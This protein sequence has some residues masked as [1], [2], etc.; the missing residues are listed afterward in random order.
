MPQ[1]TTIHRDGVARCTRY[2]FGPNKLHLCGPDA[3]AEVFAYMKEGIVDPGLEKLLSRFSTLYPYLEHIARAN[4]IRDPFDDRVVHAYWIGNELLETITPQSFYTHLADTLD[5][6]H[7]YTPKEF[8]QLARKLPQGARMHHSFHVFNAYKRTGHD[9]RFHNLESMDSCRI[10]WG[11]VATVDGPTIT[12]KRKP[13]I[14]NGHH[15]GLGEEENFVVTRQLQDDVEFDE[16]KPGDVLSLHWGRLCEV[17]SKQDARL[18]EHYTNK[19][20]ALTN[21]TL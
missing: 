15:I 8:E 18:L 21:L 19:H 12:L 1:D 17:I 14:L 7:K 4:H 2:A 11:T 5:L 16:L 20:I 3:N 13:L 10:S 9:A 6:K